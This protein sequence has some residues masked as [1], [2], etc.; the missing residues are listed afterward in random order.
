[1]IPWYEPHVLPGIFI[2]SVL[3]DNAV[4]KNG[5]MYWICLFNRAVRLIEPL[6]GVAIVVFWGTYSTYGIVLWILIL[7][8]L[9]N[10]KCIWI[11]QL[12]TLSRILACFQFLHCEVF[13]NK[14]YISYIYIIKILKEYTH[15]SSFT[16]KDQLELLHEWIITCCWM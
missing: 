6:Y 10:I 8:I 7:L 13:A 14:V 1:M 15:P 11:I 9:A 4:S 5:Y 2:L 12:R 3:V 16:D